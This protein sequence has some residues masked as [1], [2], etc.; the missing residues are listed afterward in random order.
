[1]MMA[2]ISVSLHSSE[3]EVEVKRRSARQNFL[4]S[5]DEAA[6]DSNISLRVHN[7][8]DSN[9]E[10]DTDPPEDPRCDLRVVKEILHD[11]VDTSKKK[12]KK[13]KWKILHDSDCSSD[14]ETPQIHLDLTEDAEGSEDKVF[15]KNCVEYNPWPHFTLMKENDLYDAEGSEDEETARNSAGNSLQS[16]SSL[17]D[18]RDLYNAD[19]SE[20][21][22]SLKRKLKGSSKPKGRSISERRSKV[23]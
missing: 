14:E 15:S 8:V 22:L 4:E 1:M 16:H 21:E 11:D 18:K 3:D 23:S 10:P 20:G 13:Q 12:K 9:V 5:D 17:A 2:G 7:H 19:G 6:D